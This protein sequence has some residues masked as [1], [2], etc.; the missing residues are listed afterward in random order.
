MKAERSE[1]AEAEEETSEASRGWL[2]MF[3]ERFL[4]NK[5]VQSEA[6]S[7]DVET[8]AIYPE[9]LV[10]MINEDGYYSKQQIV[11][12]DQVFL[13]LEGDATEAFLK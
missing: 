2:M 7:A 6:A 11:N 12:V 3:K 4:Y 10:E 1:K 5:A 9:D 13:T 8:V